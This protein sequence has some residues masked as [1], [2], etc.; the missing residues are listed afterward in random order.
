MNEAVRPEVQQLALAVSYA[1]HSRRPEYFHGCYSMHGRIQ[2]ANHLQESLST[3][4]DNLI[5]INR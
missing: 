1:P 4:T 5:I 3:L 2:T